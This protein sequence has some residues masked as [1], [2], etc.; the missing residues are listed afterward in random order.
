MQFSDVGQQLGYPC[1]Q[2]KPMDTASSAGAGMWLEAPNIPTIQGQALSDIFFRDHFGIAL[3]VPP[4][5]EVQKTFTP[6]IVEPS[7]TTILGAPGGEQEEV[8][9]YSILDLFLMQL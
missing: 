1:F 4:E 7:V 9:C 3:T 2:N 5:Q 8:I 6:T